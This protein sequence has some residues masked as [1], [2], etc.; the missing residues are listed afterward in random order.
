MQF[1]LVSFGFKH[2]VPPEADMVVD[3]RFLP[4]PHFVPALKPLT[5]LDR[6]VRDF[7]LRKKVTREFLSRLAGFLKFLLPLYRKEGKAYFT[8]AVGC[9]GGRHRSVALVEALAKEFAADEPSVVHRDA[10]RESRPVR[11]EA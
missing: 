11:R 3:A 6:P 7:V 9:T 1:T 5:G 10:S 8:L 2:G 4:N